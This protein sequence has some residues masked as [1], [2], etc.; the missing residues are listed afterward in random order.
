[1]EEGILGAISEEYEVND[2]IQEYKEDNEEAAVLVCGER[3]GRS[4]T[5]DL[6]NSECVDYEDF[7]NDEQNEMNDKDFVNIDVLNLNR[8]SEMEEADVVQCF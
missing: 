5:K 8:D 2:L 1:M 4:Q 6:N 3:V 7:D